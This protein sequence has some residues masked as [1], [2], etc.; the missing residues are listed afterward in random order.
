MKKKIALVQ[1]GFHQGPR[2]L[3]AHFLPYSAGVV[4]AY[5]S[6]FKE[7]TDNYELQRLYWERT[8]IEETSDELAQC[9]VVGFSTY[10]WNRNYNYTLARKIKELNPDCYIFFGGPEPPITDPK[11]FERFPFMDS[12]IC[13]EGEKTLKELLD[14]IHKKGDFKKITGLLVNDQ[15][16]A[17]R[18]EDRP[19]LNEDDLNEAPSPYLMGLFDDIIEKNKDTYEFNGTLETNRG[20]PYQCTFCDW[21]SYTYTKIRKFGLEKV[22]DE[23]E[24]MGKNKLGWMMITDANFGI[25]PERDNMIADK[26]IETRKKYGAPMGISLTWAKNQK[27]EVLDIVKKLYKAG[28]RIQ[29]LTVSAQ[30][31]DKQVL[32]NIKRTNLKQHKVS[33]IFK[34]CEKENI[35]LVT[36]MILGLPGETIDTWKRGIYEIFKQGNHSGVS[37][38]QCQILENA[39]MNLFQRKMFKIETVDTYDY[40]GGSYN[41]GECR[42]S[43]ESV[44]STSTM[45]T[46]I[47]IDAAT[48]NGFITTW[49]INGF[50]QWVARFLEKYSKVSFED[51]YAGLQAFVNKDPWYRA[52]EQ[53]VRK[54]YGAWLQKGE[55]SCPPVGNVEIYGVTLPHK[56]TMVIH[57]ERKHTHVFDLL[58]RY[59]KETYVLDEQLLDELMEF[60]QEYIIDWPKL[61]EYPMKRKF[62]FDFMGYIQDDAPLMKKNTI[63]YRFTDPDDTDMSLDR[64]CEYIYY[65][66]KR[67]FGKAQLYK[68]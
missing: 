64:F 39:D 12:A 31:M 63:E 53:S 59:V 16:K 55:I 10:V 6:Q 19:R 37:T 9:D 4:W 56:S 21:G 27:A 20:C 38:Y 28:S 5:C 61:K 15:G 14:T 66:W 46:N 13:L 48:W 30:S 2:E 45:P 18:T 67:A 49:H 43:I 50:S 32:E 29:G 68:V 60:Q 41:F 22:F 35:P 8:D 17:F 23:I 65:G 52:E 24:W 3:N 58:K 36:E 51:F 26:I 44:T 1:V 34:F 11:I 62:N 57:Q 42:E 54:H 40:M 25:F 7:I 33:E 47:M